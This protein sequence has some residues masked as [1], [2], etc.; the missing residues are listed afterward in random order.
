MKLLAVDGNSIVNRA[1]YGV[2][3]LTTKDGK[4]YTNAIYG[5]LNILLKL[6][7]QAQPDAIAIA[8][9]VREPTFRH[10]MYDG[11]KANR[12]GM[13]EELASQMPMLKEILAAMGIKLL[14][15][16]GW[17]ADDILGTLAG[18]CKD[19]DFCS[20]ATGDRDSLQLVNDNVNVLLASTKMGAP[21]TVKYDAEKIKEDYLVSSPKLLIDIKA[22]QGDASDCIPGVAGVGEKTAKELVSRFGTIDEIY[23]NFDLLDIKKGVH[24]KLSADKDM[25]YLSR[26]L[27]TIS[28]QAPVDTDY[29]VY[30]PS[31]PDAYKLTSLLS[32]LEMFKMIER[33]NLKP[34]AI[35]PEEAP[36]QAVNTELYKADDLKLL[37]NTLKKKGEAYFTFESGIFYFATDNG[38]AAVTPDDEGWLSFCEEFLFDREIQKYTYNSKALYGFFYDYKN[39]IEINEIKGDAMLSAYIANPSSDCSL[40]RIINEFAGVIGDD[41]K[42]T[43]FYTAY[44]PSAFQSLNKIIDANGQSGLLS[45]IELPLSRVLASMEKEGFRVDK[46]G[47]EKFGTMLGEKINILVKEIYDKAGYEFN[48]NSPKQLGEALFVKMQIPT[49]KK[50]KSGFSTNAEVL[51]GLSAEYPVVAEILEYR[52]LTKL[53][54]TY[55]DGLLKVIDTDGRVHSTLNQT[56]TRTGRISSSEPNLQNIPVRSPLGKE[57]RK[58]FTAKDGYVLVDADY[59]QIELRVLAHMAN[60]KNMISAFNNGDD[61]HAITASQVFDMPL[62]MVTPLMR[63]RAKA[64]NFGIVYGIGPFSLSKNTG[65]SVAEAKEYINSYLN[66]FS[67][68][69]DFMK[70]TVENAKKFGYVETMFNRR[71]YLP[72][73][74]SSNANVRAA[75]ERMAM[76]MPIQGTAA[77]IIKIAMIRVSDALEKLNINARLILQVHDELIVEAPEEQ[78]DIV[79]SILKREME[80][81][82]DLRVTMTA[83]VGSGKTWYDAKD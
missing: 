78:A 8:F 54:S 14:E 21:V 82:V 72:E 31:E 41:E 4:Y 36:T 13:P 17:E 49:K 37:L 40:K 44:L 71:R 38:V 46:S 42:G 80:N 70:R 18:A 76:N 22:L 19:G 29:S 23:A 16:P 2:K 26:T 66:N 34:A 50:T 27:G 28:S 5:F 57:M 64:V 47:I 45:D 62:M 53:K 55:C 43:E 52:T 68:V 24:D 77:D 7:T 74:A 63:S 48:L 61:I 60:D 51:E 25:A 83:D 20:I 3:L 30:V 56:E 6:E 79:A 39:D 12:K 73:L 65:V 9:D 33:L 75:A 67:G 69:R 10:K 1:F 58:F 32:Q 59:S 81:A 35:K 11:Y 15:S